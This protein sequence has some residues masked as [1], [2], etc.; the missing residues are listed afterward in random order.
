M[1]DYFNVFT[2]IDTNLKIKKL[3]KRLGVRGFGSLVFL[4]SY[5]AKNKSK[6][7][8]I[9]MGREDI[10]VA[11]NWEGDDF[12]LIDTLIEL[13]LLDKKKE[14]YSIHDWGKYNDD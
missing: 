8:L 3:T 5:T 10:E 1:N 11:A 14:V 13:K 4:W 7:E 6:G 2:S 9:G 12:K